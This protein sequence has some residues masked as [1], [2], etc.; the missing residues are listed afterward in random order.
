MTPTPRA[1]EADAG[2]HHGTYHTKEGASSF[3]SSTSLIWLGVLVL[4]LC[5]ILYI[6]RLRKLVKPST[7]RK[8]PSLSTWLSPQDD[9]EAGLMRQEQS[10]YLFAHTKV[11]V[12]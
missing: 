1:I 9:E 11:Y 8:V 4:F 12:G 6:A 7:L 2:L 3:L 5:I 10:D